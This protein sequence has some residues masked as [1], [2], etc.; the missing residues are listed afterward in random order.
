MSCIRFFIRFRFFV[1]TKVKVDFFFTM[2]MFFIFATW[3]ESSST[4]CTSLN[5]H[6]SSILCGVVVMVSGLETRRLGVRSPVLVNHEICVFR[7]LIVSLYIF[8]SYTCA[9]V[10]DSCL[11]EYYD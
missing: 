7:L 2:M 8:M 5:F 9:V 10:K 1:E 11:L 3:A 4:K 6:F